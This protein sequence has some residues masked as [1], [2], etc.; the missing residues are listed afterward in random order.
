MAAVGA[1]LLALQCALRAD[2]R[3]QLRV[4]HGLLR[5]LRLYGR[6]ELWQELARAHWLHLP[7]LKSAPV[8]VHLRD[9]TLLEH[10]PGRRTRCHAAHWPCTRHH[11]RR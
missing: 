3:G 10:T 11:W 2:S 1:R 4:P 5:G 8:E 9:A 6:T 7:D